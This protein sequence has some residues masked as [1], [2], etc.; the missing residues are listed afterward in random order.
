[1][2]S[3]KTP[4]GLLIQCL[5]FTWTPDGVH[6][7]VWLSVRPLKEEKAKTKKEVAA[8]LESE[9][10]KGSRKH[11]QNDEAEITETIRSYLM[12]HGMQWMLREGVVCNSCENKEKKWFWRM[13]AR[14]GKACLWCCSLSHHYFWTVAVQLPNCGWEI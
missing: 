1:M 13:E 5:E 4:D 10:V 12:E 8:R 2:D 9:K 3:R 11:S 6:Q 7:E 14:W